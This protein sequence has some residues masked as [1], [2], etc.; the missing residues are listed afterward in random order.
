MMMMRIRKSQLVDVG[1]LKLVEDSIIYND[2]LKRFQ[3]HFFGIQENDEI[4]KERL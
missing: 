1:A 4:Y 3:N 2:L